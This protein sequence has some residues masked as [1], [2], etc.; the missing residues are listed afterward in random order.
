MD[1]FIIVIR[2]D[3]KVRI[4]INDMLHRFN[5]LPYNYRSKIKNRSCLL[6]S[7]IF[8]RVIYLSYH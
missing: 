8:E 4:K 3:S 2:K 7:N 5:R 6:S 1:A